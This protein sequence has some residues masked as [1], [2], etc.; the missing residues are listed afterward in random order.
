MQ[1]RNPSEASVRL[2][3]KVQDGEAEAGFEWC[4][5]SPDDWAEVAPLTFGAIGVFEEDQSVEVVS[6]KPE[7]SHSTNPP[8]KVPSGLGRGDGVKADDDDEEV[9][10]R[11]LSLSTGPIPFPLV[12][13]R[14]SATFGESAD[15]QWIGISIYG[16]PLGTTSRT[17]WSRVS[18]RGGQL[19]PRMKR[20][21]WPNDIQSGTPERDKKIENRVSRY[22]AATATILF[23]P[24][25]IHSAWS[26]SLPS[27][28]R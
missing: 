9:R 5:M 1:N 16:V 10:E 22:T 23:I 21:T 12:A 19:F 25:C 8:T 15:D 18:Q 24:S 20:L 13:E 26:F 17:Q 11:S 28:K 14:P 4:A 27:A 2:E 3:L 6:V 7:A